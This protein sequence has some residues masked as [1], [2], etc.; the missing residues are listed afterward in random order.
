MDIDPRTLLVVGGYGSWILAAVI[1]FQAVR[2]GRARALPDSWTM[3]LLA[4][5]LGLVLISQRGLI[6]DVWSI[7]LANA[8]LMATPLFSYAALQRVRG[9][10]TSPYLIASVPASVAVFLVLVGFSDDAF[11][12][13]AGVVLCAALFG[14]ALGVWSAAQIARSGF[15][16]GPHLIIG[17]S[18]MLVLAFV[19]FVASAAMSGDQGVFSGTGLQ[20]AFYA[21][22][23]ACILLS[24][25]GYMDIARIARDELAHIEDP[26]LPDPLT[27]LF[28]QHAFMRVGQDELQRARRRRYPVC[29]MALAIEGLDRLATTRGRSSADAALKR[30]AGIVQNDIRSYDLAARLP[31]GLI[32]VLLPELPLAKGVEA[33]ERL[34]ARVVREL[35]GDGGLEGLRLS[36][37]VCEAAAE[38]ADLDALMARAEGCLVSARE[39]GGDRVAT[40]PARAT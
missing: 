15:R 8:L 19:A 25:L 12:L 24:T 21:M 30:V 13:R 37:G 29:A 14:L 6:A 31:R 34:R 28:S 23:D 18:A 9:A 27:G 36:A 7:S 3:G 2:P 26:M 11:A 5:G 4:Q 10:K 20:L 40:P 39:A 33:A 35:S 16:T 22:N 38:E 32:G 17:S 1:E